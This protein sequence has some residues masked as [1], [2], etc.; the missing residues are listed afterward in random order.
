MAEGKGAGERGRGAA[1]GSSVNLIDGKPRTTER[2]DWRSKRNAETTRRDGF[3]SSPSVT[4]TARRDPKLSSSTIANTERQ[5]DPKP[6][7]STA[8]TERR[9]DPEPS[10]SGAI[11]NKNATNHADVVFVN[12]SDSTDA[13]DNEN[14]PTWTNSKAVARNRKVPS[15]KCPYCSSLFEYR[16]SL[17]RHITT[18]CMS[19]PDS[20]SN[21]DAGSYRCSGCGRRYAHFKSLRFHQNHECQQRVTCPDCNTTMIGSVVPERHKLNHCVNRKR[22]GFRVKEEGKLSPDE[23]FIDDTS[24]EL[25]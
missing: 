3:K 15:H 10:T 4:V 7:T 13:S 25:P 12:D 8:D 16:C 2:E 6:S 24:D 5:Q 21:K 18:T 20:K 14:V 17:T 19:N 1:G 23:L 22:A 9:R 11:R